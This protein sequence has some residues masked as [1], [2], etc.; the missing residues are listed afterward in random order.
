MA[1]ALANELP[2]IWLRR[3]LPRSLLG[4]SIMIIVTPLLL[5]QIVTTL[6]FYQEHWD[7]VTKRLA[8]GVAG[9]IATVIR[10]RPA[11]ADWPGRERLFGIARP[12][13]QLDID[14]VP[15][16]RLPVLP[17]VVRA[18]L[19]D[20]NLTAALAEFVN[21]PFLTD[22]RSLETAVEIHVQ[23][24]DGVLQVVVP[25]PPLFSSTTYL[26]IPGMVGRSLAPFP[27]PRLFFRNPGPPLPPPPPAPP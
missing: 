8:R 7:T 2:M 24:A 10:L 15:G 22:T 19:V 9:D 5:L 6:V 20:R 23:L 13:M 4:R 11:D 14:F 27:T 25:R 18:T 12:A 16:A 21:R 3:I 17:G 26:V 1:L